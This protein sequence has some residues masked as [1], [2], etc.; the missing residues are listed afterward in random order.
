M[1]SEEQLRTSLRA[2]AANAPDADAVHAT[3]IAALHRRRRQRQVMQAAGVVL[4]IGSLAVFVPVLASRP[5]GDVTQ[6][7][8]VGGSTAF[9]APP[10]PPRQKASPTGAALPG[11]GAPSQPFAAQHSTIL[12]N[13]FFAS[14]YTYDEAAALANLWHT[15]EPYE[16]K[17]IAGQLLTDG[18]HPPVRDGA[19][20]GD[21]GTSVT[22]ARD[23][24]AQ[25]HTTAEAQA[26]ATVWG[27]D[28]GTV[29]LI[30]G[31]SILDGKPIPVTP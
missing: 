31:Q 21:G 10:V 7:V 26:L 13:L 15:D 23:A 25:Q 8:P 27:D 29:E 9:T 30:V 14:G 1:T 20:T 5:G 19:V 22:K 4:V 18:F 28:A 11:T 3:I 6:S 17:V 2:K 24:F 12:V 16:A